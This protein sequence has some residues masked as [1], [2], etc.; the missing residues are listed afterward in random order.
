MSVLFAVQPR[1]TQKMS[2]L[3]L[4]SCSDPIAA[5]TA[6][7]QGPPVYCTLPGFPTGG[8]QST[9]SPP[10]IEELCREPFCQGILHIPDAF[11]VP[12]GTRWTHSPEE[13]TRLDLKTSRPLALR[14]GG[15][16]LEAANND[17]MSHQHPSYPFHPVLSLTYVLMLHSSV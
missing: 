10:P 4:K 13:T 14:S 1:E 15:S 12:T 5:S 2:T 11:P 8:P 7:P 16:P 17:N 3:R 6:Q 9:F